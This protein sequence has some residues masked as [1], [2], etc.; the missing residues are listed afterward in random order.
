M[1]HE[2]PFGCGSDRQ[3]GDA[4]SPAGAA[5]GRCRQ[6]R[7]HDRHVVGRGRGRGTGLHRHCSLARLVRSCGA[8]RGR[9]GLRPCDLRRAFEPDG[10]VSGQWGEPDLDRPGVPVRS[11]RRMHALTH[12][13]ERGRTHD[14]QRRGPARRCRRQHRAPRHFAACRATRARLAIGKAWLGHGLRRDQLVRD[15]D[16]PIGCSARGFA[17]AAGSGRNSGGPFLGRDR[18]RLGS[19]GG[20]GRT[21]VPV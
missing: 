1:E 9:G 4:G 7:W 3:H 18:G 2:S 21:L 13:G 19:A 6:R 17:R 16:P 8:G 11:E 14:H 15:V 10:G 20:L 5:P 12:S